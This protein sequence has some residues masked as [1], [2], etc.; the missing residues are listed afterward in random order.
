MNT[1]RLHV[2]EKLHAMRE[3][4]MNLGRE[5]ESELSMARTA[6][7][8]LSQRASA[9]ASERD[10]VR[11]ELEK[12]VSDRE[13]ARRE[14]VD[15]LEERDRLASELD[16]RLE[17]EKTTQF[18]LQEE[19]QSLTN[20][21]R[22]KQVLQTR[23]EQE[24]ADLNQALQE[25]QDVKA[26]LVRS[27]EQI[28]ALERTVQKVFKDIE[29]FQQREKRFAAEKDARDQE[30]V[31][32]RQE[33]RKAIDDRNALTAELAALR[34]DFD[35]IRQGHREEVEG[36]GQRMA[37]IEADRD[38]LLGQLEDLESIILEDASR[39]VEDLEHALQHVRDTVTDAESAPE[40]QFHQLSAS[41]SESLVGAM[42][43]PLTE[44]RS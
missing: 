31:V 6:Y 5:L 13:A 24:V 32:A 34:S 28:V 38:G 2:K 29:S 22:E 23:L 33:S 3:R 30:L 19:I 26:K 40:M 11:K 43:G 27:N 39:Q 17:T 35:R 9:L 18:K 7:R 41:T 36:L 20:Q 16:A 8:Q 15:V 14:A 44:Q 4:S 21:Q 1:Q 37:E 42:P 25:Q 12:A 10:A